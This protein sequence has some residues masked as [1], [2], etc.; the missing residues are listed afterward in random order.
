M[1]EAFDLDPSVDAPTALVRGPLR[2]AV[3]GD[4]ISPEVG[5]DQAGR[6][7]MVHTWKIICSSTGESIA[8]EF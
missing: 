1:L 7:Q 5:L 2:P 8:A 4:G 3:M 6:N